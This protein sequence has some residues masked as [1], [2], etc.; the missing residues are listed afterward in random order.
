MPA[1][2]GHA[3]RLSCKVILP[4]FSE[5]TRKSVTVDDADYLIIE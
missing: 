5:L 3:S 1:E 4:E 2:I